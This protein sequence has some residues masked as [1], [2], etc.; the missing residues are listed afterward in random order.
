MEGGEGGGERGEGGRGEGR[1]REGGGPMWHPA[2][3]RTPLAHAHVP[4]ANA[5]AMQPSECRGDLCSCAARICLRHRTLG[6]R[7]HREAAAAAARLVAAW[8]LHF[9]GGFRHH[10][11][12]LGCLQPLQVSEQRAAGAVLEHSMCVRG[13]REH[14]EQVGDMRVRPGGQPESSELRV[15]SEAEVDRL[16]AGGI[17]PRL[18][19]DLGASRQRRV[20][21]DHLSDGSAR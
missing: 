16:G 15:T 18:D 8:H 10:G 19:G 14:L 20:P 7:S 5:E 9:A 17:R 4:M 6:W 11:R 12:L 21:L 2:K 3:G 1:A 13:P